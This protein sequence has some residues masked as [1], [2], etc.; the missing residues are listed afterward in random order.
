M[1][2]LSKDQFS[3]E[4]FYRCTEGVER[5]K[6][7]TDDPAGNR[8]FPEQDTQSHVHGNEPVKRNTHFV[9]QKLQYVEAES[10]LNGQVQANPWYCGDIRQPVGQDVIGNVLS[11]ISRIDRN[12]MAA[13]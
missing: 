10:L 8:S 1:F 7:E 13:F 12:A 5:L 9:S 3:I 2:F 6:N 4:R 11:M